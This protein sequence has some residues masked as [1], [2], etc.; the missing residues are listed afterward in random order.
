[1]GRALLQTVNTS[2]QNVAVGGIISPGATVR[3]Y[4]CNC[5]LNGNAIEIA[6]EGYYK[7]DAA[8]SVAPDAAGN[9]IVALYRDG[10]QLPGAIAYGTVAAEGDYVTLPILTTIR[11]Y[12]NCNGPATITCVLTEGASS[13]QNVSIRVVKD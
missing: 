4:G 7:I 6:G 11:Q 5:M 3:R 1:M 10:V 2:V 12:C 8:I 9:V 13:V